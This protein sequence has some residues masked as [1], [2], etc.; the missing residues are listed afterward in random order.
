MKKRDRKEYMKNYREKNKEKIKAYRIKNKKYY[1]EHARIYRLENKE[2]IKFCTKKNSFKKREYDKQHKLKKKK[3]DREYGQKNKIRIAKRHRKYLIRNRDR[4]RESVIKRNRNI[5]IIN[6][7]NKKELLEIFNYEC[8]YC[9]RKLKNNKNTHMDH[10]IPVSAYTKIGKKCPHSWSNVAP[11]HKKCNL[12]KHNK[13][14]LE[15]IWEKLDV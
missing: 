1:K 5:K 13:T 8:P 12:E 14:P 2:Y 6:H 15:Y 10:L 3:Y 7:I 4:H 9:N 11:V